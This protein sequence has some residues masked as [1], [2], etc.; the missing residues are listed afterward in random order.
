MAN[1]ATCFCILESIGTKFINEILFSN[2]AISIDFRSHRQEG[3]VSSHRNRSRNYFLLRWNF[4][5]RTCWNHPQWTRKQNHTLS[6]FLHRWGATHRRVCKE[7]R[8]QQPNQ[9]PLW[10]QKTDRKKVCRRVCA[11]RQKISSLQHCQQ[12]RKAIHLGRQ[13]QG[14]GN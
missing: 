13:Y 8:R 3:R 5:K 14:S 4:Q 9:N 6:R 7:Q 1:Q 2:L 10:R 11:I 12:I